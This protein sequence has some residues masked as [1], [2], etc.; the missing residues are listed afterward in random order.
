[1]SK[2]SSVLMM[3]QVSYQAYGY[4]LIDGI[5]LTSPMGHCT[6]LLGANGA[7]KSTFLRLVHGLIAPTAGEIRWGD[8]F[9]QAMGSRIT[10]VFQKPRLLR[11]SAYA[12]IKYALQVNKIP[13]HTHRQRIEIALKL[14][15]LT[16]RGDCQASLLSGGEQ[17][18]LAIARAWVLQPDVMLLDEPTAGLDIAS[19]EAV[20]QIILNLKQQSIKVI[21]AS[22]HLAQVRRL[23]DEVIFLDQGRLVQQASAQMFFDNP[24]GGV[25]CDFIR[26]QSFS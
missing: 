17:R 2:S 25:V 1:M 9:P 21:I 18:R 26:S 5:S 23:C 6:A 16:H 10:M 7:G 12:N 8:H 14:V 24:Q 19:S 15:N 4:S 3:R 22:H 11:R 20:E 13:S